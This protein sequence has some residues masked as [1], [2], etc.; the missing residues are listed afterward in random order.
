MAAH[1]TLTV[2]AVFT[3]LHAQRNLKARR[4]LDGHLEI[5]LHTEMSPGV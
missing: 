2:V 5:H 4:I 1:F 3:A